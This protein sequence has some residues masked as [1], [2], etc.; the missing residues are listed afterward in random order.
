MYHLLRLSS[1]PFFDTKEAIRHSYQ[2][3]ESKQKKDRESRRPVGFFT[4]SMRTED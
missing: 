3:I 1:I 4:S 2:Q